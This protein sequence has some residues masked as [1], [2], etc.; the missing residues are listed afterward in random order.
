VI[1]CPIYVSQWSISLASPITVRVALA[2]APV[3]IFA[4]QLVEG[5]LGASPYTSAV[6]TLC[7]TFA[8]AAAAARRRSM[9]S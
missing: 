9:R 1:V 4:F 6:E 3:V 2:L 7:C 5:R 8:L